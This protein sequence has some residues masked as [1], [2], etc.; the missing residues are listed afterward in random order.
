[1]RAGTLATVVAFAWSAG[2][3][4]T[5]SLTVFG[6]SLVD[7]G[8]VYL[9][10]G[11]AIPADAAGYWNGRF[12]DGP[13]YV[14]LLNRALTGSYTVPALAG[15]SNYA[16]GGARAAGDAMFGP[17]IVPGLPNQ[18]ALFT[19]ATGGVADPD[20]LYVINFGN[21][22]VNAIQSGDT[23]GLS[24]EEYSDLFV[25]NIL[26]AMSYLYSLGAQDF[27]V[28]GVPN[29]LEAEGRALQARLDLGLA[30][31]LP[32]FGGNVVHYDIMGFFAGIAVDPTAYGFPADIDLTGSCIANRPVVN[33]TVDCTGYLLFDGTHPVKEVH[34]LL[35]YDIGRATDLAVPE[36]ATWAMLITGF[37]VVGASLRR[38]RAQAV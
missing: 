29:P 38:R 17:G 34:T 18:L 31:F 19:A 23:Y 4:A 27:L 30:A 22:D 14:D 26:G 37:G 12:T 13:T 10:T 35:A 28:V 2:A 11:G 7:A 33:G 8:N 3:T 1:M 5:T 15:G 20:A 16:V 24:V 6:D 9:A 36:P 32:F 21:N 25:G